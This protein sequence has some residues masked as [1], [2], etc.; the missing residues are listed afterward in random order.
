MGWSAAETARTTLWQ[1]GA[2]LAAQPEGEDDGLTQNEEDALWE[3]VQ[4]HEEKLRIN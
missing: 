1:Y 3:Q 4:A 2:A